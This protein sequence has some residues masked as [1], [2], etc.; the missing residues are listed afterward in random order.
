MISSA[1]MADDVDALKER[2][3]E[4]RPACRMAEFDGKPISQADSDKACAKLDKI[5]AI[6]KKAGQCWNDGEQEWIPCK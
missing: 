3:Y 2:Y 5:G 4:N 1:A 6:L